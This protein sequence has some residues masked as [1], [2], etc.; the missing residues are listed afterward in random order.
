VKRMNFINTLS[1]TTHTRTSRWLR[2]SI[3]LLSITFI[4]ISVIQGLE[5]YSLL[6]IY[7][8][9]NT[10]QT[11]LDALAH[12][13]QEKQDLENKKN[14]LAKLRTH[15]QAC[16]HSPCNPHDTLCMLT[17]LSALPI[18]I[19]SLQLNPDEINLSAYTSNAQ[20]APEIIA[21]LKNGNH[22]GA[23]E[24]VSIHPNQYGV[25]FKLQAKK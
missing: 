18:K 1:A 11:N 16:T 15:I 8:D 5:L 21:R 23:V 4:G 20:Y 25:L 12:N 3:I 19:Q 10:L 24:L 17:T 9:L 14:R 13:A 22:F 6:K 7:S 2:H